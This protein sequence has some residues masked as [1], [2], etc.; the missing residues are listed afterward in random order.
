MDSLPQHPWGVSK[1]QTCENCDPQP[2][3]QEALA[4]DFPLGLDPLSSPHDQP[5]GFVSINNP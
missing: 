4:C 1:H 5:L 3:N 2:R